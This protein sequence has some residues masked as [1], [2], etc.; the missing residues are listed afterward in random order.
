MTANQPTRLTIPKPDDWH[1]HLRDG[2]ILRAVLPY[3]ARHFARAIVMPNLRPPVVTTAQA[4][5][6]REEILAA[7]PSDMVFQPLMTLY[8]TD[9]TDADDLSYGQKEGVIT[10]AKL[11][12]ANATTNSEHGVTD[13]KSL[14]RV[15]ERMQR[16]GMPLLVHGEVIDASVDIFD[17][18]AVFID[19]VLIP[20]RR[21]FPEL[22]V[23]FEHITTK[24]A[25]DYVLAQNQTKFLAA[26]ITPHHLRINRNA[27]FTGGIRPHYYCLPVAKREL[28]RQVLIR[29][30]TSGVPSFFLGTDSAPHPQTAKESD[31]GCAGI[32]CSINALAVYAQAF[33]EAKA[34]DKLAA[35]ASQNG[36]AFYGLPTNKE[37]LEL[38]QVNTPEPDFKPIL[39]GDGAQ[40]VSFKDPAPLQWRVVGS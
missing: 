22:K 26:T 2:A 9:T 31:C 13:I 16:L 40:I 14:T 35:F 10:A 28:H 30:A 27:M 5:K 3:T 20:L 12:P 21:Q 32:F 19:K 29:A 37:T 18:E 36:P 39:I 8:L 1:V 33:A 17:R 23:V 6:Y 7:L 11:Y 24:E 34:L 4:G 25:V 38:E 15:F